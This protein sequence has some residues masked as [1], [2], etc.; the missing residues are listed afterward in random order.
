VL[1]FGVAALIYVVD[2]GR[3]A[4]EHDRW[5]VDDAERLGQEMFLNELR[6]VRE[7]RAA[8]EDGIDKDEEDGKSVDGAQGNQRAQPPTSRP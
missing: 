2:Q 1:F 6:R 8:P 4:S 5:L 3:F 7:S